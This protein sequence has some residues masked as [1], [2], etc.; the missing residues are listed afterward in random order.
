[1]FYHFDLERG[2]CNAPT[3]VTD[4]EVTMVEQ[5]SPMLQHKFNELRTI[6]D[7]LD[8]SS[9]ASAHSYDSQLQKL[10]LRI[11]LLEDVNRRMQRRELIAYLLIGAYLLL[12]LG[13]SLN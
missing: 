4:D 13:R 11:T 1:M 2:D 10:V 12:K 8:N 6:S 3:G 5:L 9:T 7:G